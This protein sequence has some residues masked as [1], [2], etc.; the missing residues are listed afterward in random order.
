MR[1][2]R[3]SRNICFWNF[4][5]SGGEIALTFAPHP[6]PAI[7]QYAPRKHYTHGA[8]IQNFNIYKKEI[9]INEKDE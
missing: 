7:G 9:N 1:K 2:R 6:L 8:E 4:P 5:A 3:E